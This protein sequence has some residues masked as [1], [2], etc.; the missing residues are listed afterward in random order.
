M[1]KQ[2][3]SSRPKWR[4]LTS[5]VVPW[6]APNTVLNTYQQ[7][8]NRLVPYAVVTVL[9][10]LLT[11]VFWKM[12]YAFTPVNLALLYLLPVL[13]SAVRWGL[14]PSFYAAFIAVIAFDY[15]F[16]PPLHRFSVSDV[17]YFVSFIVYLAVAT[18][19]ASLAAQ[20]RQRVKEARER[21]AVTSALYTLSTQVAA[22]T[23]LDAVLQEI[24]RHA[25][26]TF[27][28][29][30]AI[31]LPSDS[32]GLAVRA[33]MG[34]NVDGDLTVLDPRILNWVFEH[35]KMAG[36]GTGFHR[37]TSILYVPLKTESTV[38]GVMCIGT[39]RPLGMDIEQSRLRVVLA[40]AGLAAVSIARA[41]YEEEAQIAHLSAES[42]RLRTALLDS[43]SHELRTP[44]AT[45]I[46]AATG[47]ADGAGI[48]S[49][50]DQRELLM[51]VRDGAMRMN[52]LV[53]NLLGMVRLESG[54][55]QLNKKWCDV[56][57]IVGVA[58]RQAQDSLQNRRVE[59]N[60]SPSLPPI[61]VD[62]V[63]I[64]QVLV[65]LL[66]NAAKYSADR[67]TICIDSMEYDGV[68]TLQVRD[69]GIGISPDEAEKVFDKFYRTNSGKNVPGTGLGLAICKGIV[70]AH[71]GEIFAKPGKDLGTTVTVMLPVGDEP[72][73]LPEDSEPMKQEE[74]EPW[75][76]KS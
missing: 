19:T 6:T 32:G 53:T 18:F 35:G 9:I 17:R 69:Q 71:G 54:M 14:G 21:E 29:T 28:L 56:S 20:L 58:L 59:V 48:L 64:E 12:D 25:S 16:V 8:G 34:L 51:T 70:Q 23:S 43:I 33:N 39:Q 7:N 4:V 63:L 76:Q 5:Y 22:A 61:A 49:A 30:A 62:E 24:V 27:G 38:H 55:L 74:T 13:V 50:E 44:L 57:D 41:H 11:A 73:F 1:K 15:F 72:D 65:N 40:L 66:S 10:V 36:F 47:L 2:A 3:A 75:V 31:M 67:S 68:L 26:R 45:I 42:E 60:L 52:R 46:G 37:N